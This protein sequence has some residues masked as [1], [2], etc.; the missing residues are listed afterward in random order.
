MAE[1]GEEDVS[2]EEPQVAGKKDCQN[3]FYVF[4]EL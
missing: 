2:R 4:S 3:L 1:R